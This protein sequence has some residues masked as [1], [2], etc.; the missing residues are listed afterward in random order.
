M[1]KFMVGDSGAP[2][3]PIPETAA[4]PCAGDGGTAM[5]DPSSSLSKFNWLLIV[6]Q[7]YGSLAYSNKV[8]VT[9]RKND[10]IASNDQIKRQ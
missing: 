3:V 8:V 1:F 6:S 4:A 10:S 5:L 7:Y 2:S 9:R